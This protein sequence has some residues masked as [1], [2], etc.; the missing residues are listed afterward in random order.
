LFLFFI[1]L[2]LWTEIWL[3]A[4]NFTIKT[5]NLCNLIQKKKV[6]R[7]FRDGNQKGTKA[8]QSFWESKK[9][10]S[11]VHRTALKNVIFC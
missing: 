11:E 2:P 1:V 10:L 7:H 8:Q 9:R 3:Q 5:V 6:F 4:F